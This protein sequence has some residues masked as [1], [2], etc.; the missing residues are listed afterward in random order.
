MIEFEI[1]HDQQ[2]KLVS[3]AVLASL[4]RTSDY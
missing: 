2:K 4:I 3:M 1:N